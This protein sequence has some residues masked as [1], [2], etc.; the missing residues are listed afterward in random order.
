VPKDDFNLPVTTQARS[1]PGLVPRFLSWLFATG[2]GPAR[3]TMHRTHEEL[4]RMRGELATLRAEMEALQ[5]A[6][7]RRDIATLDELLRGGNRRQVEA[8]IRDRTQTVPLPDGSVLCRALGRFKMFT[9]AADGGIAPHLLLDGYWEYWVTEFVCRNVARGEIAIDVG[10]VYGYYTIL[11]ADLVGSAGRVHALEPN[12]W[13]HWLLL[14]NVV[15]NGLEPIVEVRRIA[16]MDAARDAVRIPALL[17]GPALGPFADRFSIE[18]GVQG[19]AAPAAPLQDL[20][21]QGVGFLRIGCAATADAIVAGIPR[22]IERNPQMR[23]LLEFDANRCRDAAAML[24]ALAAHYPL[25]FVD[26]DS[27]AKPCTIDELLGARRLATLFL[28]KMEP[29]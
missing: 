20:V 18:D 25:R 21:P 17:T 1:Q 8:L 2:S 19:F 12:P 10:A 15:V 6:V 11:L 23:I 27:R 7:G 9:D 14:R 5:A 22:M 24:A 26:G 13:L 4:F 28:S 3:S 29:C 16:A